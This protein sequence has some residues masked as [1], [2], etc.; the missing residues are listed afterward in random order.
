MSQEAQTHVESEAVAQ[1]S[2]ALGL[3]ATRDNA[4]DVAGTILRAQD[5]G[6]DVFVVTTCGDSEATAFARRLGATV[7]DTDAVERE[8]AV[9]ALGQ[10]ARH[11]GYPGVLLC[12]NP[13]RPIDFATSEE[14]LFESEE[15]VEEVELAAAVDEQATILAAIPAY[16]EGAAIG[17]VVRQTQKY[18]DSVLVIDDGS[19]DGTVGEAE[20]AG[21]TV[22]EHEVNKGYGGALKTAF[23]EAKRCGVD[24]LV[25]LDGDGQHDPSDIPT[26]VKAQQEDGVEVVIG[27]RFTGEMKTRLPLYRRFGLGVVNLL[28]NL[29][30]GVVRPRS[31]VK[32]T[33]SGYRAYSRDAI[34]SLATDRTLGNNMSAS[35]DILYHAHSHDYRVREVG[36]VVD[37]DVENGSTHSPFVHGFSLVQ[38]ILRTVERERPISVLGAPGFVSSVVGIGFS[39]WTLAQYIETGVFPIGLAV[40]SVFFV[41]AG[42]FACFTAIILHSLQSHFS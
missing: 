23:R 2:P 25:I 13:S 14:A 16:N 32:D 4:N 27:S 24:H 31:R 5:D 15:Y 20:S 22:I 29:S 1:S 26:M 33:Q 9:T 17:E 7:V 21:A 8:R 40:T 41:L 35:T 3:I 36:T 28:T 12:S 37:Y 10:T 6:Y 18:V 42:I 11:Q 19:T 39:Y 34:E 30:L 38:N